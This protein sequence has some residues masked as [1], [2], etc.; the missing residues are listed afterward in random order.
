MRRRFAER[1]TNFLGASIVGMASARTNSSAGVA[2]PLLRPAGAM[3][4]WMLRRAVAMGCAVSEALITIEP[5]HARGMAHAEGQ[6]PPSA[7]EAPRR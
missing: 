2:Q 5:F 3:L 7:Y 4:R 1:T 6:F